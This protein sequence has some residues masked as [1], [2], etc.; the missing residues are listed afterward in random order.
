MSYSKLGTIEAI[1]QR[2]D[3]WL[4]QDSWELLEMVVNL[5]I[6]FGFLPSTINIRNVF[7]NIFVRCNWQT[8]SKERAY[9]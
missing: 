8:V 5:S 4:F 1:F 6:R 2:Y 7:Y 3:F 9:G